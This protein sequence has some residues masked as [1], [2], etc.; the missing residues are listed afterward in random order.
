MATTLSDD[1]QARVDRVLSHRKP[2]PLAADFYDPADDPEPDAGTV[3]EW[4]AQKPAETMNGTDAHQGTADA[5]TEPQQPA[6]GAQDTAQKPAEP[7]NRPSTHQDSPNVSQA[8]HD[9]ATDR[10]HDTEQAE[11][12]TRPE[13]LPDG[14]ER[15]VFTHSPATR[16]VWHAAKARMA[17]PWGTLGY[18]MAHTVATTGP[19]VV[20]PPIIGGHASLNMLIGLVG[21]SGRGKGA[22]NQVAETLFIY[23]DSSGTPI[24]TPTRGI[25]S[26]EGIAET[27]KVTTRTDDD[28]HETTE[29]KHTR[30]LFDDT[31][32]STLNAKAGRRGATLMPMLCKAYM[33]EDMSNANGD[34]TTSRNVPKHTYRFCL[35]VGIQPP[36]AGAILDDTDGGTP[37]RFLWLPVIDPH[38]RE[39]VQQAPEPYTI[40]LPFGTREG[41]TPMAVTIPTVA[42]KAIR[43]A[44]AL[45]GRGEG[46]PEDGH[47]LLTQE[48][49]AIALALMDS[50]M[51]VTEDDWHAAGA[52]IAKSDATRAVCRKACHGA[53]VQ[54]S[55]TRRITDAEAEDQAAD[56]TDEKRNHDVRVKALDLLAAADGQP[57]T[58]GHLAQSFNSKRRRDGMSQRDRLPAALER[59][60]DEGLILATETTDGNGKPT[61]DYRLA[62]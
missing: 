41:R 11:S 45:N 54:E 7:M 26:G 62:P 50:R 17:G 56:A 29:Q 21:E 20:A 6:P 60:A 43:R 42:E 48:K 35:T 49:A 28:G 44:R 3:A 39:D 47:R 55:V 27:F 9:T 22:S 14:P 18:V 30:A 57:L 12:A 19:H 13:D 46:N 40:R 53:A 32:V 24:S 37:Q 5:S 36:R 52:V 25:G 59:L 61:Q 10:S 2:K 51:N 15:T 31:E 33:G 1:E 8:A 4:A 34:E 38:M 58:H 16:A 23:A